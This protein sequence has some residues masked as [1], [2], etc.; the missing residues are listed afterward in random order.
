MVMTRIFIAAI[1]LAYSVCD[2]QASRHRVSV[3]EDDA[4][5][6]AYEFLYSRQHSL[7]S[8]RAS[9]N[10]PQLELAHADDGYFAFKGN[11]G[12]VIISRE[13]VPNAVIG[14]SETGTFKY[15]SM[16]DE[17]KLYLNSL[18]NSSKVSVEHKAI[19]PMITTKWDQTKPYNAQLKDERYPTGCVAT[20]M[21]QMMAY[22]K[23]PDALEKD[24]NELPATTFNWSL[25]RDEYNTDDIDES[26]QEV[27]KLM[28]YCGAAVCMDYNWG[29]SKAYFHALGDAL[30]Y[31]FGYD[32][33]VHDIYR[34]S[35]TTEEW[36]SLIYNE[37]ANG[38]PVIY[39]AKAYNGHAMIC[40]G[41]DGEGYYHINWGWSGDYDGY[42]LLPSLNGYS[43]DQ[44]ATIGIIK[45]ETPYEYEHCLSYGIIEEWFYHSIY[46]RNAKGE[47]GVGFKIAWSDY[48]SGWGWDSSIHE[49]AGG[50]YKNHKLIEVL[51]ITYTTRISDRPSFIYAVKIGAHVPDGHYQ[52]KMLYR[53]KNTEEWIE[54][55]RSDGEFFDLFIHNDSLKIKQNGE[56]YAYPREDEIEISDIA[57]SGDLVAGTPQKLL[58]SIANKGKS[59]TGKINVII[60]SPWGNAYE[61]YFGY[62]I[63]LGGTETIEIPFPPRYAGEY[64]ILIGIYNWGYKQIGQSTVTITEQSAGISDVNK[65]KQLKAQAIW[66]IDGQK[67]QRRGLNIVRY[68]DGTIRKVITK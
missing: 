25:M 10:V 38:R 37:L 46:K 49:P 40:D 27:A 35:Y 61:G 53:K 11:K 63:N 20:A 44:A 31:F 32:K 66:T 21:A 18:A 41:Y 19:P 57:V 16:P 45:A 58:L 56:V 28:K 34:G 48:A 4:K 23:W 8:M 29:E 13:D 43:L 33:T 52:L 39:S 59:I 9:Q 2:I 62:A 6:K 60:K 3:G 24:V 42:Y 7:G 64:E 5:Q 67:G 54:P 51:P 68:N 14:Y 30:K 26:A 36:D 17:L 65:D 50:L 55:L 12:F 22:H 47:L 15:E 1:L